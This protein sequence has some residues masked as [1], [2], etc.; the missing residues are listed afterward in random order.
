MTENFKRIGSPVEQLFYCPT[1]VKFSSF[2]QE[3]ELLLYYRIL[4]NIANLR[5]ATN[6]RQE[7]KSSLFLIF[8]I[9]WAHK[10]ISTKE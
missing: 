5:Y 7:R 2:P 10:A 9:K 6:R 4:D 3:A 8:F 1:F